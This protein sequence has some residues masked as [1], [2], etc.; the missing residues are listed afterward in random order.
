MYMSV[1]DQYFCEFVLLISIGITFAFWYI[2]KYVK[3]YI[4][5]KMKKQYQLGFY[6]GY[7]CGWYACRDIIQNKSYMKK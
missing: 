6:K 5:V 3:K 4:D 2:K 1:S 7:D